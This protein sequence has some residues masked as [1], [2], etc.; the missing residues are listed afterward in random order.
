LIDKERKKKARTS[1]INNNE[2]RSCR[3]YMNTRFT[4]W[5]NMQTIQLNMDMPCHFQCLSRSSWSIIV[6][7]SSVK[8]IQLLV[9]NHQQVS[10]RKGTRSIV[11]LVIARI[12]C[13]TVCCCIRCIDR[14]VRKDDKYK[15]MCILKFMNECRLFD[16][17]LINILLTNIN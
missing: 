5:F 17:S 14:F 12:L 2:R 13:S 8:V 11:L 15:A 10:M 9:A 7:F 6:L 3:K 1:I 16:D 4:Y